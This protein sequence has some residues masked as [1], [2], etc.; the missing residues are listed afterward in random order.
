MTDP[1][2]ITLRDVYE[3]VVR[4]ER[5]NAHNRLEDHE[6]RLRAIERQVF[7]WAGGASVVGATI[8]IIVNNMGV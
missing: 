3:I 5:A 4:L 1:V 2:E 8:G 7:L 6:A